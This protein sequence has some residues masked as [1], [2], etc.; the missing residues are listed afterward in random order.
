MLIKIVPWEGRMMV[1]SPSLRIVHVVPVSVDTQV[2][3]GLTFFHILCAG[4]EYAVAQV[5][6]VLATAVEIV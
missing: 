2:R 1:K 4:T 5:N 3:R 6:N